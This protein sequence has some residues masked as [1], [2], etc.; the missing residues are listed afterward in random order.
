MAGDRQ[1]PRPIRAMGQDKSTKGSRDQMN[2]A[3]LVCLHAGRGE[4][5]GRMHSRKGGGRQKKDPAPPEGVR[6]RASR[7]QG[8]GKEQTGRQEI[9][10]GARKR[11]KQQQQVTMG[12]KGT[13]TG[14]S[15]GQ[16]EGPTTGPE[17]NT[18]PKRKG[19]RR[20]RPV[21]GTRSGPRM[22][23]GSG[24]PAPKGCWRPGWV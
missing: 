15:G 19:E 5:Q 7:Q 20:E 3:V 17:G 1:G 4:P 10:G 2:C 18:P 11:K 24:G 8:N 23:R 16:E 22:R 6:H 13:G 12:G 21:L 9:A 14:G